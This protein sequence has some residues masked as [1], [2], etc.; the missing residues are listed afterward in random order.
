VDA[1]NATAYSPNAMAGSYFFANVVG[2]DDLQAPVGED[3]EPT[4]E[5]AA[6]EMS[7]LRIVDDLTFTVTL[8]APFAQFP[9]TVGYSP[10]FPLPQAFFEDPE[11]FGVRPIGNGP[12]HAEEDYVPG[13]GIT[14][15][16][17]D[18]Y[19][20]PQAASVDAIE[21]RVYT[22]TATAYT[23]ALDGGLDVVPSVPAEAAGTAEED[24][25]G[26]YVESEASNFTFLALPLYDERYADRRVRQ[27]LSMS[28]D[29]QA[30]ADALF[31]GTRRP[32]DSLVAPVVPGTATVPAGTA[33]WT[34]PTPT[35]CSTKPGSTGVSRSSCG[36]TPVPAT[37]P[38][39]RRS[40][41]SCAPTWGSSSSSAVTSPRPS[42]APSWTSRA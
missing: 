40:A 37:T 28:I 14:L 27:A 16:R 20:G 1:W 9:V 2:Y 34:S 21:Y 23:D 15:A 3:G 4:G 11:G 36:S 8:T 26:R 7:G 33:S 13:E 32:A 31:S 25:A 29:R 17:Y 18:D 22:D 19:A 38:G 10:F 39:W 41:T 42:T 35:P 24:F 12:F 30:I 6:T 5:P